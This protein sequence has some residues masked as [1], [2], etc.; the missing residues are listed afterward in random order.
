MRRNGRA[1]GLDGRAALSL[2]ALLLVVCSARAQGSGRLVPKLVLVVVAD[3]M[4]AEQLERLAPRFKGA[5]RT[6]LDSGAVF[7]EAHHRHVPTQTSVGHAAVL[8]GRSPRAHGIVANEWW[9]REARRVVLAQEDSVHGIGPE[10]LLSYSL[11]DALKARTPGSIVVA[12]SLKSKAAVMLGGKKA[13][14]VLW[15]DEESRGFATS[16]Y[17]GPSPAWLGAYNAGLREPGGILAGVR[18]VRGLDE[19]WRSPKA[20]RLMADLAGRLLKEYRLGQDSAPDLLALGFSGTDDVGHRYGPDSRQMEENLLALDSALAELLGAL[21]ARLVKEDLLVL[22]TSDH[23]VMPVPESPAGKALGARRIDPKR[24]EAEVEAALQLVYP[25]PQGKLVDHLR[26][27]HLYLNRSLAESRGYDWPVLLKDA[28]RSI[29]A[30][31]G[32]AEVFTAAALEGSEVRG[33][34]S[35]Y[36]AVYRASCLPS[37]SGDLLIRPKEDF[38]FGREGTSHSTPYR[39]DTH[40]PLI[41]WGIGVKAGSFPAP[42]RITDAAPTLA[43]LLGVELKAEKDGRV[44]AEILE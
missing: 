40:V 18:N 27:P 24:F 25:A 35:P 17:Y 33:S 31:A 41:F 13:D 4:K 42:A 12:A 1:H 38:L 36:A 29:S 39:Y 43:A 26:V 23:G 37:R 9:D 10:Q 32:V 30:L 28:A 3:Q 15:L 8:T 14:L 11:G 6:L 20:H 21:T 16:S 22:F 19:I 5:L 44:L 34:S 2:C 7:T